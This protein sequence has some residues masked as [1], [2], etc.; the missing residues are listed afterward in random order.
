MND[1]NYLNKKFSYLLYLGAFSSC[2]SIAGSN[3]VLA[4]MCLF[5]VLDIYRTRN[6]KG[7]NLDF[8]VFTAIYS[9]KAFTALIKGFYAEIIEVRELWDKL[10]SLLIGRFPM[11]KEIILR[12]LHL[13]FVTNSLLVVYALLQRYADFPELYQ[14]LFFAQN[15]DVGKWRMIGY[16]GHPLHYGGFISIVILSCV[17]L[18]LFYK[19]Y[20]AYYLPFLLAGVVLSGSRSYFLGITIAV[21]VLSFFKSKRTFV[22]SF[23]LIPASFGIGT[24]LLPYF[25]ERLVRV[26]EM[27]DLDVRFKFW[28]VA[29]DSFLENPIFGVGYE[30]FSKILEPLYKVGYIPHTA[31]AHSLYM[32]ELAEGGFVG[33]ALMLAMLVYFISKYIKFSI[34]EEDTLLKALFLGLSVTFVNIAFAGIFEYNFGAA[35]V[36]IQ[37]TFMMGLTESYRKWL[38]RSN[39]QH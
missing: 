18:S 2:I 10:P 4:F 1:K 28:K 21:F 26:F 27:K 32:Q 6:W 25:R 35:V 30:Q 9:W 12:T 5:F 17:S 39:A 13:L 15:L 38:S 8:S 23:F 36:W 7:S 33:L 31:H 24:L 34:H 14:K 3:G 16:F 20:F 22:A 19:R 37:L 11:S 29:W